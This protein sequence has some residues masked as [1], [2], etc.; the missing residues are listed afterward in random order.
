MCSNDWRRKP[1]KRPT[2]LPLELLLDDVAEGCDAE[3]ADVEAYP[4]Q[5]ADRFRKLP[6]NL[7]MG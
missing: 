4:L 5:G 6:L 2:K 1:I 3:D 7:V